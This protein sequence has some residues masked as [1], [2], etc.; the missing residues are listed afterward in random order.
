MPLPIILGVGAAIAGAVGVGSG[1]HG[2]SKMKEANDTMKSAE[3]HHKRNNAK[4]ESCNKATNEEMDKLGILE[5]NI[6]NSFDKF[7][8][9][10]EQ[11]QNRP[12]FKDIRIK[13]VE[14]P[15]YNKEELQE[16]SVGAGVLLGGLGGA[17]AGTAGG[18]RRLAQLHQQ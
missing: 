18:L 9:M 6:L 12:Q 14:L 1:I 5:L 3:E 8:D 10:I 11:I 7:A 16:V 17:A 4:L 2:A 13:G 15:K